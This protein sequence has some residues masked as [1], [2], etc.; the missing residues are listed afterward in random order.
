MNFLENFVLTIW[1]AANTSWMLHELFEIDFAAT[2][3]IGFFGFGILCI[4]FYLKEIIK[5]FRAKNSFN[6]PK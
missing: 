1:L 5:D 6:S 3:A 2:L 4:P